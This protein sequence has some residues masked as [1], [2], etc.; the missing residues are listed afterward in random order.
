VSVRTLDAA[1]APTRL[2]HPAAPHTHCISS[3]AAGPGGRQ[4]T[5]SPSEGERC[6]GN[7]GAPQGAVPIDNIDYNDGAL[8]IVR[9]KR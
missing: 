3:K 1:A 2:Q 6:T 7:V 5:P 8:K 9:T 4:V